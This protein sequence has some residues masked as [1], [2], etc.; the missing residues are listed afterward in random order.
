MRTYRSLR[1]R[2]LVELAEQLEDEIEGLA[3]PAGQKERKVARL[4][5]MRQHLDR[6]RIGGDREAADYF[7]KLRATF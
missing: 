4:F 7:D 2:Q 3:V 1:T 5:R 6:R